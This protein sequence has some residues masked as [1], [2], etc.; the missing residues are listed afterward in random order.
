MW[1]STVRN[2]GNIF[3]TF[4]LLPSVSISISNPVPVSVPPLWIPEVLH[5]P[6]AVIQ[7]CISRT[8]PC[9]YHHSSP[10]IMSR[11]DISSASTMA[12]VVAGCYAL[13]SFHY[14]R[15]QRDVIRN[16][17]CDL[18]NEK[19]RVSDLIQSIEEEES[20]NVRATNGCNDIASKNA[21]STVPIGKIESVYRLCVGT[22]RQ[23]MLAPSS[24][25][26]VVLD[27]TRIRPD[28]LDALEQYSHLW[29]VFI[30]HLN[31][32]KDAVK[33]AESSGYETFPSKVRPP[34]LGGKRVGVFAT[35]TPHRPAPI[36]FSLCKIDSI[37]KKNFCVHVSGLDLVD[38]TPVLDIK[39]YVPHYDSVGF[40]PLNVPNDLNVP[41]W[42]ASGLEK[43]RE[44]I[45][46]EQAE[47]DLRQIAEAGLFDFYGRKKCENLET[48]EDALRN[49]RSC[50]IEVLA[51]DVRSSYQTKKARKGKSQ[52][53]L[54]LKFKKNLNDNKTKISTQQL[55][56]LLI[57][58]SVEV[59]EVEYLDDDP[60]RNSGCN[61]RVIIHKFE[62]IGT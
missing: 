34:A 43:R 13:Y 38:G 24:R 28:S 25:G 26:R 8:H 44:V 4:L 3:E 2:T 46:K 50:V 32:N 29:I 57:H 19:R 16:L 12:L 1:I 31:T 10:L 55:D 53:G 18:K 21:V 47:K 14:F 61:D 58:F 62:V 41:N 20:K 7:T 17:E 59:V 35:R 9:Y 48:T 45:I 23:G 30:F 40:D 37:D 5:E 52:A 6:A 54:T 39:P 33:K 22:P 27:T 51:A 11:Q 42:V 60:G 49:M 15:Q 56:N 36:G